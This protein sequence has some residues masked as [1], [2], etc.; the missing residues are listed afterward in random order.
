[1]T[2][3]PAPGGPRP[4]SG[5]SRPVLEE[6]LQ[7]VRRALAA[8]DE[9]PTGAWVEE[10]ASDLL[11]GSKP[12]W[13]SPAPRGGLAFYAR[14]GRSAFGHVHSG[15]G[16]E[17]AR[18]LAGTLLGQLPK[19]VRTLDLGFTGL[20]PEDERAVAEELAR[21]P[22]ST[23]IGREAMERRLT[24]GD[25]RFAAEPPAGIDRVPVSAVT[26]EALAEL[27]RAA[28]EGS[29]DAMLLGSETDAYRGALEA[30]LASRLGRFLGEASAALIE[31]EPTRLVGAV[32]TAERS[33]RRA[34]VLDLVVDPARRRRGLGRFLLGWT[35]RAVWALGYES[36]RLWV[37]VRNEPALELYRAFG[38]RP[39]L[40]AT[41]Y[42]WERPAAAAQ[43]H[44]S[45]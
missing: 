22:G 8:R 32:L 14:R 30:M 17:V 37:S 45:A 18:E 23:V 19:D 42:R 10:S 3:V 27:D 7:E 15:A 6:L 31:P 12:G 43:P 40:Q 11:R 26:V 16:T 28:F 29:V 4:A 21:A 44:R 1:M 24:A 33:S 5:A 36:A 39:T 20:A 35:L 25:G 38:F 34:I 9:D 2:G 41:I 13:Y